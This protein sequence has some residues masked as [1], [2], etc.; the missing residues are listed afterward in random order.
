[1]S[2][3]MQVFEQSV[4]RLPE[5]GREVFEFVK[6]SLVEKTRHLSD[7]IVQYTDLAG[8]LVIKDAVGMHEATELLQRK[9]MLEGKIAEE[10]VLF[11][12]KA[13]KLHKGV[14]AAIDVLQKP[15]D[16]VEK[17]VKQAMRTWT[18]AEEARIAKE[19]REAEE[20][21]RLDHERLIKAAQAKIDTA[22]GKIEDLDGKILEAEKVLAGEGLSQ[23]EHDVY[24]AV[25]Q[26]LLDRKAGLVT[27]VQAMAAPPVPRAI[28]QAPGPE[29]I[30]G[31]SS[32][33]VWTV[34]VVD[35]A[36]L[37]EA[38]HLKL[39]PMDVLEAR[40]SI[41]KKLANA[42]GVPT[43]RGLDGKPGIPGCRLTED[44]NFSVRG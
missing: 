3:E 41:L 22:I 1:M 16:G 2:K 14:C 36:R 25:L 8:E 39:V 15:L 32:K 27:K 21:A 13:H 11:K 4:A 38:A 20:K 35:M 34:E 40:V 18:L 24:S 19:R 23:D 43:S 31:L 44:L 12:D 5:T 26:G 6:N 30:A 17:N 33:K 37:I 29:K 9:K 28:P 10:L 7:E 42:G